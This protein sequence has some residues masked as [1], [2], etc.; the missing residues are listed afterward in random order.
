MRPPP[1]A[2]PRAAAPAPVR[3]RAAAR[4]PAAHRQAAHRQAAQAP[5][6]LLRA[7]RAPAVA[8]VQPAP[9]RR[10]AYPC[11]ARSLLTPARPLTAVAEPIPRPGVTAVRPKARIR[12]SVSTA[13]PC[14]TS[15]L[16]SAVTV[17]MFMEAP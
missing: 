15:L 14:K 5:A 11:R 12:S 4:A 13:E 2:V 17:S 9:P 3:L 6:R 10:A 7:L 8:A 1:Q 16:V